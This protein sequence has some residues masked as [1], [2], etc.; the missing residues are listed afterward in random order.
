MVP[1]TQ[2]LVSGEEAQA[3]AWAPQAQA[4]PRF[5]GVNST[6]AISNHLFMTRIRPTHVLMQSSR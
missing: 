5:S 6:A 3:A 2:L 4:Q 1:S